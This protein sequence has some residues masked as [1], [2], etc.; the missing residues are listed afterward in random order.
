MEYLRESIEMTIYQKFYV[1]C[2]F[3]INASFICI[4]Q[5]HPCSCHTC[6]LAYIIHM[7]MQRAWTGVLSLNKVIIRRLSKFAYCFNLTEVCL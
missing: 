6:I 5:E 1:L 2:S 3:I 7:K 4:L